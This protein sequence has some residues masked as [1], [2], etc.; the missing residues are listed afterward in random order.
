MNES[1]VPPIPTPASVAQ[2]TP[3]LPGSRAVRRASRAELH[4]AL[5]ANEVFFSHMEMPSDYSRSGI[6]E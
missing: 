6:N 5:E 3:E 2:G 4:A 1:L